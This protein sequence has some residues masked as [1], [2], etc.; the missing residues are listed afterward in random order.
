MV[1]NVPVS[2]W[3]KTISTGKKNNNNNNNNNQPKQNKKKRKGKEDTNAMAHNEQ[4][5]K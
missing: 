5:T 4:G 1:Y 3:E 2:D